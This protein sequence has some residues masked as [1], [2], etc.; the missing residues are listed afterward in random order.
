MTALLI[1]L[2]TVGI[3]TAEASSFRATIIEAQQPGAMV[4][5]EPYDISP[6]TLDASTEYP[7]T[8]TV[9]GLPY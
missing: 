3:F 2:G 5:I 6:G 1:I 8:L 7:E 9:P 4:P